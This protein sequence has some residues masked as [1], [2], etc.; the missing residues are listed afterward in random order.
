[1]ADAHILT[2]TW[3]PKSTKLLLRQWCRHLVWHTLI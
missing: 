1:M 2:T 3:K